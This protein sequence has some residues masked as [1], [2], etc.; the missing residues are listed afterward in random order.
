MEMSLLSKMRNRGVKFNAST[1]MC[2]AILVLGE[3][4]GAD[5]I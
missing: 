5:K 2:Q 1:N 4:R 3:T